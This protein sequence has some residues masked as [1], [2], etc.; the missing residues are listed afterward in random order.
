MSVASLDPL[1]SAIGPLRQRLNRHAIYDSLRT[2]DDLRVF[3]AHH[4]FS[5]WDFMSLVKF[6][7]RELAPVTIPWAPAGRPATRRFI[8]RLVVE[9][10]SDE[11]P[12][13]ADGSPTALSHFELY[14][15]AM[16]EVGADP[17]PA[18]RF[19]ALARERGIEAALAAGLAPPASA[20]FMRT[21]FGFIATAKPHV[22]AAAFALGREHVIPGMFRNFLANLGI[23][24]A[25]APA[26]HFYLKRHV[27]LDEDYHAPLSLLILEDACGQ[28][29]ARLDEAAAAAQMAIEARLALW[30]GVQAAISGGG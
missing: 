3:M 21:T 5:V 18:C 30:D 29:P 9:E 25:E 7:Q 19:A 15:R 1:L 16:A 17:A 14:G 11:G 26:F 24:E 2:V 20:A 8:N 22:V 4:V 23:G 27:H 28:D 6:M 10:E 12:P 13:G